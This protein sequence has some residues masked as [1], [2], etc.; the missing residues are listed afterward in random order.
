[1][2]PGDFTI[3]L[4]EQF[5]RKCSRRKNDEA[6]KA[7]EAVTAFI[8]NVIYVNPDLEA[9]LPDMVRTSSAYQHVKSRLA[10]SFDALPAFIGKS[11]LEI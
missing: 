10:R 8:V 3:D 5:E 11:G 2:E 1:M 7:R 9:D 6:N 4:L